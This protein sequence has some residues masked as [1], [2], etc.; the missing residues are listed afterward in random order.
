MSDIKR[1]TDVHNPACIATKC[2]W[3]VPNSLSAPDSMYLLLCKKNE[4]LEN[5]GSSCYTS[6]C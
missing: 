1:W 3:E 2:P 5:L 6:A 4:Y